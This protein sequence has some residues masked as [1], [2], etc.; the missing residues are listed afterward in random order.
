MTIK[1]LGFPEYLAVYLKENSLSEFTPGRVMQEHRE[2]YVVS[3]GDNEYEAE[4]TGNLRFTAAGRS[5]FPAVGDWVAMKV[6]DRGMAIIHQVLPRKSILERQA[7]SKPGDIQIISTNVDVAFVVQ[8][9]DTNFSINRLER[10]MTVCNSSG[11][12][13]ILVI[14]KIDLA[15]EKEIESAVKSVRSAHPDVRIVLLN[16]FSHEGLDQI[17]SIMNSGYTYCVVGSSGTGKSTLINNLLQKN[18]IRT[19][20]ISISTGKG[21]HTTEHRELFVLENGAVIIDTPGM[22]ELGVTDSSEGVSNTFREIHDLSLRCKFT[23]C[24]H[25]GEKGCAVTDALE[26]GLIDNRSLDNYRRILR[27]QVHF[28]ETIA[29]RR[30]KDREFGKMAKKVLQ[31]KK[32]LK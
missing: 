32:K 2:R 19:N 30:K 14:S 1:D 31:D 22:R 5:D 18:T 27:E 23:D 11:I 24:T 9:I 4:I 21:K 16:N 28:S 25:S 8:S 7:V 15:A 26:K 6:Y 10:Y 3:T 20:S 12:E 29:E 13:P 17:T